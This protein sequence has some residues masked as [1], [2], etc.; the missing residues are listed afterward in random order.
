MSLATLWHSRSPRERS[1]VSAGAVVFGLMLVVALV[2]LPLE[3]ARTRLDAE[4]PR[5]RASV[6]AL[7]RDADEV[8]RLKALPATIPANPAPLAAV[9]GANAWSRE[10]PGVQLS[11]PDE[12]HVRLAAADV[13][14]T[15]LLDW[16]ATARAAHGLRVESARIDALALPGRVRVELTLARS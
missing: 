1:L 14:F 6:A 7:T 12:K 4:L 11:V 15:A 10:L 9:M 2:W 8:R 3:R 13:S 16:L 5:L